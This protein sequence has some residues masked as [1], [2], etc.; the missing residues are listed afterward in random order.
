MNRPPYKKIIK[1]DYDNTIDGAGYPHVGRLL[2][3]ALETIREL[4]YSNTIIIDTCRHGVALQECIKYMDAMGIVYH[5]VNENTLDKINFFGDTRKI[6][7]D[8]SIDDKNLNAPLIANKYIDWV[9]VR[10]ILKLE[11]LD[12]SK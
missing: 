2:P 8:I 3:L 12:I 6:S 7:A 11:P 4:K 9:K 10:E 1:I 5:Y